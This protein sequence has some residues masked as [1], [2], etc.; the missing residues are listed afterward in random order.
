MNGV[1]GGLGSTGVGTG[2]GVTPNGK[3][4]LGGSAVGG[5]SNLKPPVLVADAG[6]DTSTFGAGPGTEA[7]AAG[8]APR[9]NPVDLE[10]PVDPIAG[11]SNSFGAVLDLSP[12]NDGILIGVVVG[13]EIEVGSTSFIGDPLCISSSRAGGVA[14]FSRVIGVGCGLGAAV[15]AVNTILGARV[16]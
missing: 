1:E 5:R 2:V 6:A 8:G 9:V 14:V 4:L 12:G 16:E 13:V 10:A 3:A 7:G 15:G 11:N